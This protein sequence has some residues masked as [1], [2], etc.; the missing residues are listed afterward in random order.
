MTELAGLEQRYRRLLAWYPKAFR[1]DQG[2]EMLGV[3]MAGARRGQR[4]PGLGDSADL[5]RS[6]VVMRVRR[7]G[8]AAD[9]KPWTDAL[10]LF[11]LVAPLMLLLATVLE[12]AVPYHLPSPSSRFPGPLLRWWLPFREIGGLSL[13]TAPDFDIT[14]GCL[15]VIAALVLLGMRWPAL[16]AIAATAAYWIVS[17]VI[18]LPFPLQALSVSVCLLAGAALLASPGPRR[19]RELISWRLGIVL[20]L[21]AAAVQA[22]TL[23]YD[24]ASAIARRAYQA[25]SPIAQVTHAGGQTG[26][27]FSRVLS[28]DLTGYLI[29]GAVLIAI[30]IGLAVAWKQ[31]WYYL[32]LLGV[33][34]YPFTLEVGVSPGLR[35][36]G[37]DLIAF[38][39]PSHLAVLFLPPL[40][41]AAA[42]L[43][44]AAA[45]RRS[46]HLQEPAT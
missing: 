26:I 39:G 6:A 38:P 42:I 12:V 25:A 30:A 17:G 3:L 14:L 40:L 41:M 31:G 13:L 5:I 15:T 35:N 21:A 37:D 22:A 23:M 18:P 28:P 11:S 16:A 4:R 19:G 36:S 8:S 10:A 20:L 45:P 34:L 2:E 27:T 24:A 1:H 32:L 33:T 43:I 44:T 46:L 9:S 29:D 7:T